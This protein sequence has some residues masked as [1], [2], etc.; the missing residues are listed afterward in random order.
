MFCNVLRNS[1]PFSNRLFDRLPAMHTGIVVCH[2]L[3]AARLRACKR[4]QQSRGASRSHLYNHAPIC[5]LTRFSC[6][7]RSLRPPKHAACHTHLREGFLWSLLSS[8]L[9]AG[10]STLVDAACH[11]LVRALPSSSG[12]E[13]FWLFIDWD[14]SD[15]P[16][17]NV[18]RPLQTCTRNALNEQ[19][20][21]KPSQLYTSRASYAK[22]ED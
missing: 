1:K 16:W 4:N 3:T 20:S 11:L 22:C 15:L 2:C 6:S 5:M 9:G 13:N 14:R 12:S 7:S 21:H 10:A 18:T 8:F 17:S 19:M